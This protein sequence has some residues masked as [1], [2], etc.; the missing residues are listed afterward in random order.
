MQQC[1]RKTLRHAHRHRTH[2][3]QD[4]C[5]GDQVLQQMSTLLPGG[6]EPV[7]QRQQQATEVEDQR[8]VAAH[9]PHFTE[10]IDL[11][12]EQEVTQIKRQQQ[13]HFSLATV[14][15]TERATEQQQQGRQHIE[16]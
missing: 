13:E 12:I 2:G 16:Q 5:P 14:R 1:L 15:Q 11:G 9:L 4:R 3:E 7:E 8:R 10:V 6:I